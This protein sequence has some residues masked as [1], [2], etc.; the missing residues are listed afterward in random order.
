[1]EITSP[2]ACYHYPCHN[3]YRIGKPYTTQAMALPFVAHRPAIANPQKA[4]ALL[5]GINY[6]GTRGQLHGCNDDVRN[7]YEYF[8]QVFGFA[9]EDMII[10]T[11]DQNSPHSQPTKSNIIQALQWLVKGAQSK[12]W[13]YFHYSGHGQEEKCSEEAIYPVDF[14]SSGSIARHELDQVMVNK[15]SPGV[16]LVVILDTYCSQPFVIE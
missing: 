11:E 10:L 2:E 3:N 16:R 9:K 1:M 6:F 12:D 8:I 15:L 7:M 14:K 5:V 13:L 4:K